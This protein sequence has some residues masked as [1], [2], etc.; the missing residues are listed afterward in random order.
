KTDHQK[1]LAVRD[2]LHELVERDECAEL[3]LVIEL[4]DQELED[5][6]GGDQ[7]D[8]S[9]DG[10]TDEYPMPAF[11]AEPEPQAEAEPS[12]PPLPEP[13]PVTARDR[14]LERRR[15]AQMKLDQLTAER[16]QSIKSSVLRCEEARLE[17]LDKKDAEMGKLDASIQKIE[18][19][20][21]GVL[22][23]REQTLKD[24]QTLRDELGKRRN[25]IKEDEKAL[26]EMRD[27]VAR[28]QRELETARHRDKELA[29]AV[30]RTRQRIR[31]E[32]NALQ[33]INSRRT[34]LDESEEQAQAD[35]LALRKQRDTLQ[36]DYAS[37]FAKLE[38][39]FLR[40]HWAHPPVSED[41]LKEALKASATLLNV[42]E[43]SVREKLERMGLGDNLNVQEPDFDAVSIVD[44][45]PEPTDAHASLQNFLKLV[46][47]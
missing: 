32:E 31:N 9:G 25:M 33:E 8:A 12:P 5:V 27:H 18:T 28:L 38:D 30:A 36:N 47:V 21:I 3:E 40:S 16:I 22:R 13:E 29:D 41:H 46:K 34:Q 2:F 37:R 20:K 44:A 43:R 39:E 14:Q 26:A 7:A 6:A 1:L 17:A 24:E 10:D 4:V 45:A 35:I 23:R 11:E 15:R 19:R 42:D